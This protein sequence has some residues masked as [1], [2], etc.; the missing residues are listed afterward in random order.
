MGVHLP[1]LCVSDVRML[2]GIV[3]C[4][5]WGTLFLWQNLGGGGAA[6]DYVPPTK[7]IRRRIID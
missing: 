6:V 3:A 5:I 1:R 7:M 2:T 4:L